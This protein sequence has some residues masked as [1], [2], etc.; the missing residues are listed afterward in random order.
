[1][2]ISCIYRKSIEG[3][4]WYSQVISDVS[5]DIVAQLLPSQPRSSTTPYLGSSERFHLLVHDTPDS[6]PQDVCQAYL[7]AT[8]LAEVLVG[9]GK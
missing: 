9:V 6:T 8:Y 3:A 1:M 7:K 2:P 5:C 4:F